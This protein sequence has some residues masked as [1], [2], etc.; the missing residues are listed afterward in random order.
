MTASH[1]SN[2]TTS[3]GILHMGFELGAGNWKLG[4]TSGHGEKPRLRSLRAGDL[5]GLTDEIAKAK[6]RFGLA[7]DARVVSCYEAGRDGFW[8][9]RYLLTQKIENII[10]DSSSI[11]V[12]RRKRR[13]KSDALDAASLVT[14]LVRYHAGET[15]VWSVVRVPSVAAEDERQLHRELES[16][17]DERTEHS[18]RIKGLLVS[19]GLVLA[20]VGADFREWLKAARLWDGSFVSADL[21]LRLLREFV[22]WQLVDRNIKDLEKER[23]QRIRNDGLP[24]VEKVRRLLQLRGIGLNGAW[25]LIFEL[26]GWRRFRNRKEVGGCAGLTPTPYQSGRSE[27][28][29]GISKAGNRRLRRLLVE[30]SWCW[31]Q[32]Q[33]E[34]E[35]AKWYDRRFA[36]GNARTRK[37]GIVALAR[38]LLV[39]LWKYLET[40][41]VP[42]GSQLTTWQAKVG[43]KAQG[44]AA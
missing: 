40:G 6:K 23:R 41:E 11:E 38:K 44:V 8:L 30:L 42:A 12:N 29:Q 20:E 21:Q 37:I 31:L 2:D 3:S 5:A 16:L 28:E 24:H 35:L 27:R 7:P 22:R 9:H 34:S 25:L 4:F 39:A 14:M 18:N 36:A 17:K 32:W 10:V 26:F 13:A 43:I 33:P 1:N 15:R 19:Q